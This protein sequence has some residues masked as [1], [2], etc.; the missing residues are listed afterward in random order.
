MNL[1]SQIQDGKFLPTGYI[2]GPNI[3]NFS[4]TDSELIYQANL[5]SQPL[6]WYYRDNP[7]SYQINSDGYRTQEFDSVDWANSVIIFGCSNVFGLGL[8]EK[9]TISIRLS[10]LID[11][12]VINMGINASGME[13]ALLNSAILDKHYPTPLAVIQIWSHHL[14]TPHYFADRIKHYRLGDK[15]NYAKAYYENLTH[16]EIRAIMTQMSSQIIWENKT[17]YYEASFFS[18]TATL[19]KIPH[20]I[21]IDEARDIGPD[22]VAHPG[23]NSTKTLAVNIKNILKL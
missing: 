11:K 3:L 1:I 21:C 6:D 18:D 10:S 13:V 15:G 4:R 22:Q 19:L 23:R 20:I 12:P 7:I 2:N 17:K 16:G 14:R 9:D 5:K 8:H